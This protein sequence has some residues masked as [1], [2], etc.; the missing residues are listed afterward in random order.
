MLNYDIFFYFCPFHSLSLSSD[1]REYPLAHTH[2]YTLTH[3][4]THTHTHN[5][6]HTHPQQQHYNTQCTTPP[7]TPSLMHTHIKACAHTH[8]LT[9][10][11][12]ML[13]NTLQQTSHK[14]I[15]C[16]YCQII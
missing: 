4:H 7:H 10:L 16:L 9:Q 14:N 12:Y 2:I 11:T 6:T 13:T 5:H 15:E 1:H 8:T 3:A